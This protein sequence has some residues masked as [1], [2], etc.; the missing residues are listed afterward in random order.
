MDD[1][2]K[3]LLI[4][5]GVPHH[6]DQILRALAAAPTVEVDPATINP[7]EGPNTNPEHVVSLSPATLDYDDKQVVFFRQHGGFTVLL[8]KG[9]VKHYREGGAKIIKGKLLSTPVMKKTRVPE[10]E[11]APRFAPRAEPYYQDDRVDVRNGPRFRDNSSYASNSQ[12]PQGGYRRDEVVAFSG[13][14]RPDGPRPYQ[15]SSTSYDDH[16]RKLRSLG[17]MTSR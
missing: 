4:L 5:N 15:P 10:P 1:T 16:Q 13:G 12:V 9:K 3:T 7:A 17:R 6:L 2:R 14:Q 8:G 11:P